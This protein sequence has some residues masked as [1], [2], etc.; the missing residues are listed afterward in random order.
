MRIVRAGRVSNDNKESL[1]PLV[2]WLLKL[3]IENQ[4]KPIWAETQ[5]LRFMKTTEMDNLAYLCQESID[6]GQPRNVN[7]KNQNNKSFK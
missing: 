3:K 2:G 4:Q 1:E 6:T 5:P 7:E